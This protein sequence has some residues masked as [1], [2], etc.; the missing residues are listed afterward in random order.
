MQSVVKLAVTPK[1][2]FL[3]EGQPVHSV[4][5]LMKPQTLISALGIQL[6]VP[7]KMADGECQAVRAA[8]IFP[9]QSMRRPGCLGL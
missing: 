3:G 7:T 8:S 6:V 2:Q 1:R 4:C 5:V 9:G